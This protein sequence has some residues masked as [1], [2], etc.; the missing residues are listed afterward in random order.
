MRTE[1]LSLKRK[2]KK[3]MLNKRK[4]FTR[5]GLTTLMAALVVYGVM[6]FIQPTVAGVI[7]QPNVLIW[8]YNGDTNAS[9]ATIRS[10][11]SATCTLTTVDTTP[12]VADANNYDAV[13]LTMGKGAY[14]LTAADKN[15]LDQY[16]NGPGSKGHLIIESEQMVNRH[17]TD[18]QVMLNILKAVNRN[19]GSGYSASTSTSNS[20]RIAS[21]THPVTS[22]FYTRRSGS[23]STSGYRTIGT[24][25]TRLAEWGSRTNPDTVLSVWEGGY[26]QRLVFI[27]FD[28]DSWT[29]YSGYAANKTNLITYAVKWVSEFTEIQFTSMTAS[30]PTANPGEVDV[31]MAKLKV[32]SYPNAKNNNI[33]TIVN[34]SVYQTGTASVSSIGDVKIYACDAAGV[35]S[36]NPIGTTVFANGKATFKNLYMRIDTTD[37]YYLI[38]YDVDSPADEGK[39]LKLKLCNASEIKTL[40]GGPVKI[41]GGQESG[42]VSINNVT[43]PNVPTRVYASNLGTGSSLKIGWKPSSSWDVV[44]YRVY[45]AVD[46]GI[47]PYQ[48]IATTTQAVY[49]DT[50]L[51]E[52]YRYYYKIRSYDI[53]GNESID[54]AVV[55]GV[56]DRPPVTPTGLTVN[57]PGVGQQLDLTWEPIPDEPIDPFTNK[58]DFL[59]YNLYA[60]TQ[61]GGPYGL[62]NMQPITGTSYSHIGLQDGTRYYYKITAVDQYGAESAQSAAVDAIPT[63]DTP[64]QIV[65]RYPAE[66]QDY[67]EPNVTIRVKFDDRL[68][69]SGDISDWIKLER[70]NLDGTSTDISGT[71]EYDPNTREITFTPD[72][73]LD[74]MANFRVTVK[75]GAGGVKSF[76]LNP[77]MDGDVVWT[78]GTL[79]NPHKDFK[80]NPSLCGYCHSA[81]SAVGPEIIR[82]P[83][84]LDL[85]FMCH[86][87]T[88]SS[89]DVK[90]GK[91]YNGVKTV[92]LAAGGYDLSLGSTSTHFT[93]L[94]NYVYGSSGYITTLDCNN[95]H[96]PHGSTNFRNIRTTVNGRDI[97]IKATVYG[98]AYQNKTVSGYEVVSYEQGW[99]DFCGAC[100]NEYQV[101]NSVTTITGEED[102][103][104][105]TGVPLT[106]NTGADTGDRW[107]VS[108]PGQGLYTTLPTL[109][110]PTGAN[111]TNYLITKMDGG[112]GGLDPGTYNY[113]VTAVNS[114]GESVYGNILQVSNGTAH[115]K[116]KLEW[117]RIQNAY[118]YRVYRFI[119]TGEPRTLDITQFRFLAEVPDSPQSFIDDGTYAPQV[120]VPPTTGNSKITCITCHFA[121][122]TPAT[123]D[124]GTSSRLRR[125][126]N[127]GI[128]QD[129]HKK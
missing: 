100:H 111:L 116:I 123:T 75:G 50:N 82:Q 56:P 106:G 114:V 98:P 28:L 35:P 93:D 72:A 12:T 60:A 59:G 67:V 8:R 29:P 87:G 32:S 107:S 30:H 49:Y 15:F 25:G 6:Y 23:Y 45:R 27:G 16:L 129:C 47:G 2:L 64:P 42:E 99:E 121:H 77:N 51:N 73:D 63:D 81:H 34:F 11:L 104:H 41:W 10:A 78:F 128:C 19:A 4:L 126:D 31:P 108:Y 97:T 37:K 91:Y 65:S 89:Y 112:V 118:Q 92:P 3:R 71:V 105:R 38:T 69:T 48:V 90:G 61:P 113:I 20:I 55:K 115:A 124:D 5:L 7:T 1:M 80:E 83:K 125:Y 53:A 18:D 120:Q 103:R 79:L 62:V 94:A 44:G 43:G 21:N 57:N 101:Y 95:C 117:E 110:T 84:I 70:V 24:S 40:E 86:D 58:P 122:G 9:E 109:G 46:S 14:T 68:D 102:W 66:G 13:F 36:G 54:S 85:C 96:N 88:G 119:G 74:F 26:R 76:A 33:N 127:D 22:G 52:F 39:T 17:Y